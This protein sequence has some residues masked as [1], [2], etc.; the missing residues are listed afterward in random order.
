MR[1]IYCA[2]IE[3][4]AP[5][6]KFDVEEE[7]TLCYLFGIEDFYTKVINVICLNDLKKFVIMKEKRYKHGK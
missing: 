2:F 7:G 4:D 6:E 5:D 1:K 3:V